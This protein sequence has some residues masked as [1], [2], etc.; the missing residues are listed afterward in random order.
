[1]T[2]VAMG[3]IVGVKVSRKHPRIVRVLV[4]RAGVSAPGAAGAAGAQ[5]TK[6][7]DF[8]CETAAVAAEVVR[9]VRKALE[10]L[11]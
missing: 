8:E 1:V 7:Y 9:D 11:E 5:E 2:N 4:Y 10:G 3:S 6:R